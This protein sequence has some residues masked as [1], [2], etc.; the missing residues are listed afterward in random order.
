VKRDFYGVRWGRVNLTRVY[1]AG[2]SI[3]FLVCVFMTAS[4][5]HD[6]LVIFLIA[7]LMAILEI[8]ISVSTSTVA[9]ITVVTSSLVLT[10][11]TNFG[12]FSTALSLLLSLIVALI[13]YREHDLLPVVFN[14]S[15]YGLSALFGLMAYTP[16]KGAIGTYEGH[17]T[18]LL[19]YA[20]VYI[21]SNFTFATLAYLVYNWST[22]SVRE[23]LQDDWF[24][25]MTAYLVDVVLGVVAGVLYQLYG[26]PGLVAIF[27][28]LWIVIQMYQRYSKMTEAAET[29]DLTG[30]LNRRAFQRR[31]ARQMRKQRA[32]SLLMMD[33]DHFKQV[34]DSFGHLG[35]DNILRETA[36]LVKESVG[37]NGIVSR[38]GG[39]EFC[40][41][42]YAD[43]GEVFAEELRKIVEDYRFESQSE[44]HLSISVGIASY[45]A[46]ANT[47]ESLFK[48]ADSALYEAKKH[49][50]VIRTYSLSAAPLTMR[51]STQVPT[52]TERRP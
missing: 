19:A 36:R 47:W 52:L 23:L 18:A 21:V 7:F 51:V 14:T 9:R 2:V 24:Q 31:V 35:G 38:Y 45:P 4:R 39:E 12:L 22:M 28:V 16:A 40:A 8:S 6:W 17:F 49:R 15:Q 43:N 29:D 42:L 11:V 50:N 25:I 46:D 44:V 27:V 10:S 13:R 34:N 26:T 33:L 30:L 1:F 37:K 41:L 5:V 48:C 20:V 3:A 32:L